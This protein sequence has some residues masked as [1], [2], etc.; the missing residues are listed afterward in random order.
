[1]ELFVRGLTN[2]VDVH[3]SALRGKVDRDFPQKFIQTNRGI[4]Y[5]FTRSDGR[6]SRTRLNCTF[7]SGRGLDSK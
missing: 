3:M 2:M 6:P 7:G 5:T 1:M 4:S